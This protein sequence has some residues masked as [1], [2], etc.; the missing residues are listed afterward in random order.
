[1]GAQL[2]GQQGYTSNETGAFELFDFRKD[3]RIEGPNDDTSGLLSK[4]GESRIGLPQREWK[5]TSSYKR[6][7]LGTMD[8]GLP[9]DG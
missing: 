2:K 5:D 3:E 1:M 6:P 8:Y 4:N 9:Y 7:R